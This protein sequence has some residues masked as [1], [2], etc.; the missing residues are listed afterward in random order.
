MLPKP[1]RLAGHRILAVLKSSQTFH[2]PLLLAK[3]LKK[4]QPRTQI[5][6]KV[7]LKICRLAVDRNRLKRQLSQALL[8]YLP[9]L[10]PNYEIIILAKPAIIQQSTPVIQADLFRLLNSCSLLN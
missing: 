6:F 3:V 2:S 9:Q 8:P 10:Q 4:D 7:S 1:Y 5:S